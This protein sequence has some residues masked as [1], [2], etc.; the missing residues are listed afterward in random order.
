MYYCSKY[1]KYT[2]YT[3]EHTL[4][5]LLSTQNICLHPVIV[6]HFSPHFYFV[7][8]MPAQQS[9]R[10]F[11]SLCKSTLSTSINS[12]NLPLRAEARRVATAIEQA[13]QCTVVAAEPFSDDDERFFALRSVKTAVKKYVDLVARGNPPVILKE[14][15]NLPDVV[16]VSEQPDAPSVPTEND[17]TKVLAEDFNAM[18]QEIF[19]CN[20]PRIWMIETGFF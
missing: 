7:V 17:V 20:K 6:I 14:N 12:L 9:L 8:R 19:L 18:K 3:C 16:N 13:R 4:F 10:V 2:C 1:M 11:S 5:Y 15:G